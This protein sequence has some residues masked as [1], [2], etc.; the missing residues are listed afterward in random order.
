MHHRI[1]FA[2]SHIH[3]LP[4]FTATTVVVSL[5]HPV[6]LTPFLD[7]GLRK[8]LLQRHEGSEESCGR[9]LPVLELLP[10]LDEVDDVVV[11]PIFFVVAG[12]E[13]DGF[14]VL[15]DRFL[16]GFD[17][18]EAAV[19]VPPKIIALVRALESRMIAF[20]HLRSPTIVIRTA[21]SCSVVR[22]RQIE[23]VLRIPGFAVLPY[24][25]ALLDEL[26]LDALEPDLELELQ[27]LPLRRIDLVLREGVEVDFVQLVI[28]EVD[29][30][31]LHHVRNF[32]SAQVLARRF[33]AHHLDFP[34][35]PVDYT[36]LRRVDDQR[37]GQILGL[38]RRRLPEIHVVVELVTETAISSSQ[39]TSSSSS[40][41]SR[42]PAIPIMF[43]SIIFSG[44][45]RFLF[46]YY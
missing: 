17:D 26:L 20:H 5:L 27:L 24:F 14:A 34:R 11:L 3:V 29:I 12:E 7:V 32:F 37:D 2:A 25:E 44:S 21:R 18:T 15:L 28:V 45:R 8:L 35:P 4:S 1:L 30:C 10:K 41:K 22:V 46:F 6:A 40:S 42:P 16:I 33:H 43:S 38:A 9:D 23:K 13:V 39:P 31:L 19:E 36:I